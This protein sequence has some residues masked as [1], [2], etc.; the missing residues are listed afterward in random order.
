MDSGTINAGQLPVHVRKFRI[1]QGA[2]RELVELNDEVQPIV[3]VP[4]RRN[5][6]NGEMLTLDDIDPKECFLEPPTIDGAPAAFFICQALFLNL[7]IIFDFTPNAPRVEGEKHD[8][9]KIRYPLQDI[10]RAQQ[11][12]RAMGP[13][14]QFKALAAAH[15]PP[16]PGY[17]PSVLIHAW[18]HPDDI[19]RAVMT[20]VVADAYGEAY[21]KAQL[22]LWGEIGTFA[23]RLQYIQKA[24]EEYAEGD[25]ISSIHVIV[26]QFEGVVKDYLRSAGVEPRYRFES[27]LRQ[28]KEL[29]FSRQL[30]LFPKEMLDIIFAFVDTGTFLRETGD[31]GDP[32]QE[33]NR[34]GIAHGVFTGFESKS[35]ALKYL[36]LLDALALV[37]LHDKLLTG[38]L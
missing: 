13:L 11:L 35:I 4:A 8:P 24:I 32:G 7:M 17:Y 27:C 26:P 23:G 19:T 2:G 34:H 22:A 20:D 1:L 18:R 5:I 31:V 37:L 12:V 28:L 6:K 15:W 29:V 3:T 21:W 25:Y 16:A 10:A 9:P 33:V 38:R 30:V 36:V 14:A